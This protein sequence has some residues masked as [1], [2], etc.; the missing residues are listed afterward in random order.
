MT[1][2]CLAS[3]EK[4]AWLPSSSGLGD[5]AGLASWRFEPGSQDVMHDESLEL[6]AAA[7]AVN[8]PAGGHYKR[9]AMRIARWPPS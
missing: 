4:G 3:G 2:L 8:P 7:L 5:L 9:R 1:W 6:A